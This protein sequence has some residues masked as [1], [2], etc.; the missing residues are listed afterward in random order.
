MITLRRNAA[1]RHVQEETHNIWH[2]FTSGTSAESSPSDFG[3]LVG[4]D[5]LWLPPDGVTAA[6]PP[7][8]EGEVTLYA[9][10]G[11]LT[12]EDSAGHSGVLH[13][14]EFQY[15]II[16]R[17]IRY[18]EAN[19]SRV[20]G[21]QIFR[22]SLRPSQADLDSTSQ[23]KLFPL[24]QRRNTLCVVAS[25]DGRR[26]SLPILQDALVCSSVLDPGRHLIHTLA[27]G[28]SAW[29]HVVEGSVTLQ[30]IVLAEGDGA[31]VSGEPAVSFTAREPTEILLVDLGPMPL[32]PGH[33]KRKGRDT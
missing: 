28:R 27:E 30:D 15:C 6:R 8:E 9:Y 25:P 26:G 17:G 24:G 29:L 22:I 4:L 2:T 5:E 7:K 11:D 33:Q 20:V 21:A 1:R 16:G 3:L 23:Q 13:T 32:V 14:G 18:R 12:Q 31:G 10:K 19:A